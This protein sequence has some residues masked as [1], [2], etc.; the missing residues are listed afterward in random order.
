MNIFVL[1]SDYKKAAE[2]YQDIHVKKICLE[3]VQILQNAYSLKELQSAPKTQEGNIRKYSYRNHP[4]CV[5]A[6]TNINNFYWAL[7]HGQA[8]HEEFYYRFG[9]YH[10]S[11]CFIDWALQ[12][13]P[14]LPDL[15]MTAQPQ[16]F[17]DYLSLKSETP[18]I[19]YRKYYNIAKA[20]FT[21][22]GEIVPASWTKRPTPDWFTP[23]SL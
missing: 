10:F 1:D 20:F 14:D 18:V 4:V 6:R 13:E 3:I 5:W 17:G 2:L 21:I 23:I 8:L 7:F 15:P 12:N 9:K 19:G 11:K 16:C 22:H